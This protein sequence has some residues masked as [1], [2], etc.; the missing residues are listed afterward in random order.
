MIQRIQSLYLLLGVIV[1]F[2]LFFL[3]LGVIS[4]ELGEWSYHVCYLSFE[5]GTSNSILWLNSV[6]VCIAALFQLLTIFMFSNRVK[7]MKMA[8]ISLLAAVLMTVSVLFTPDLV[9]SRFPDQEMTVTFS[10]LAYLV[11]IPIITAFLAIRAIKKDIELIN[12]A[13]RIR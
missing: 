9:T 8:R 3:K 2:V 13:D 12:A 7:Q 10:T 6:L 11:L 1:T 5:D 4:S